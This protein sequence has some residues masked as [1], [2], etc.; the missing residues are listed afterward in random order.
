MGIA[1]NIE[2]AIEKG[3]WIRKL[4]ETGNELKRQFGADNVQD[5]SIGNPVIEPPA[6]FFNML[7]ELST[8]RQ[9][10]LHRYMTN[11]GHFR[12]RQAVA[13]FLKRKGIMETDA[14][15][16]VMCVGAGGGLNVIFKTLLDPGDEIILL[17]PF[18]PEYFF[19]IQNH[20]GVSV[21]VDTRDDFQLDLEKI[22][23]AITPK[24]KG[25]LINSPN[26]PSGAVY[27]ESDLNELRAMLHRINE[28]RSSPVFLISDEPYREIY[29]HDGLPPSPVTGTPYGILVYSW[30]KSLSIPGERIGYIAVPQNCPLRN[31]VDGF[32]CCTRILGFINAPATQ[33]FIVEK[34]LEVRVDLATY[35]RDRALVLKTL[36]EAGYE[37]TAPEG[38][39]YIFPKSPIP[40]DLHFCQT[41]VNKHR[42]V[43]VPGRGFYRPG[44]FRISFAVEHS[45][46][47]KAMEKLKVLRKEF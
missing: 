24:T 36:N 34:L 23:K 10:G 15:K 14:S 44:Y 3:S 21:N 29:Y 26:N 8:R 31:L 1:K 28:K 30:S 11:A 2:V 37:V 22:E 12:V 41:A 32:I 38:A 25:I 17:T 20:G 5:L 27:R 46:L 33:Q 42:L 4:F 47:L 43:I 39:F 40:D 35:R 16:I 18:F 45:V 19:Y 9:E 7:Q 13:D 6:E